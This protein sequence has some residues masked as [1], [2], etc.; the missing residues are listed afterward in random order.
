MKSAKNVFKCG[1]FNGAISTDATGQL[2]AVFSLPKA[3][4][5]VGDRQLMIAD[6][7]SINDL[8]TSTSSATETYNAY[9]YSVSKESVTLS[10]RTPTFDLNTASEEFSNSSVD[11]DTST[12]T[13]ST[14]AYNDYWNDE[15]WSSNGYPYANSSTNTGVTV[16]NTTTATTT[17][18]TGSKAANAITGSAGGTNYGAGAYG[19]DEAW[20]YSSMR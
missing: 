3:T 18:G 6:V 17:T 4:F 11:I 14:Y 7:A 16:A 5:M 2:A 1:A 10:T 15:F 13:N 19:L 9:N 20:F 12:S 8:D